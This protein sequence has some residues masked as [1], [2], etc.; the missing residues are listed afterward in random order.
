MHTLSSEQ[1]LATTKLSPE[2]RF[3]YML[4]ALMADQQLWGLYGKNGWLLLQADDD[5]CMPI[6]PHQDFA[7]AWE[8][9]EFPDC[10]PKAIELD[11]W[12][13]QWLPGMQKNGT[14]ILTFPLSD[15]EEGIMMEAN[16]ILEAIKEA[17]QA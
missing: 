11:A 8:K 7:T 15:D 1:F 4:K 9:D 12:M 3:E 13:E 2:D 17:Q 16:E 10:E 14:L 5:V 6:W